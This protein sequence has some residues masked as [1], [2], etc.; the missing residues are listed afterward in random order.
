[1][2]GDK[3][4]YDCREEK[5]NKVYIEYVQATTAG[6][7]DADAKE[8]LCKQYPDLAPDIEKFEYIPPVPRCPQCDGQLETPLAGGT[9][10]ASCGAHFHRGPDLSD[11]FPIPFTVGRIELKEVVGR[12]S[13]GTVYRGWDPQIQR[14]VAVKALRTFPVANPNAVKRFLQGGKIEAQ[15]DFPGGI[16]KVFDVGQEQE[17]PY[18][19]S[20][21]IPGE[22]LAN[23]IRDEQGLLRENRPSPDQAAAYVAAVADA[24]EHAHQ[25]GVIHRD[26]KPSNI[27]M[28]YGKIP[29][30]TDFGLAHWDAGEITTTVE[31][32]IIG[33]LAYMSPEQACGQ[34]HL[35]DC[36]SDV[37]SLGV[38]LYELL[39]DERPFN[40]NVRRMLAQIEFDEP[41]SPRGQGDRVPRDLETICLRC[42]RKDP[43]KRFKTAADLAADLRRYLKRE[44]IES[45]PVG[46]LERLVSWSRR[47]PGLAA[48]LGSV[49]ILL[50]A[51]A[52]VSAAW[53]IHSIEQKAKIQEALDHS[54][55][56][57]AE[58]ELDRGL[59][60]AAQGDVGLGMLW[61][62]RSLET[63][64]PDK[65]TLE[66][67]IRVNLNAWRRELYA[68]T[69]CIEA[70]PGRVLGFS[71]DGR[72]AWFLEAD[73]RTVRGWDLGS[74]RVVGRELRNDQ[75]VVDFFAISPD[76]KRVACGGQ[77]FGVRVW[78]VATGVSEPS[79]KNPIPV[80]GMAYT[81]DSKALI[82]A[83]KPGRRT[84]LTTWDGTELHPLAGGID[85]TGPMAI[86]PE[87]NGRSLILTG[88]KGTELWRW[89][90][91]EGQLRDRLLRQPGQLNKVAVSPDG[92]T[93]LT[94]DTT[95]SARVWDVK[96]GRLLAVLPHRR[97]ITALSF[98]SNGKNVLTADA[99]DAIRVWARPTESESSAVRLNSGAVRALAVS[100]DGNLV[101]TR[102]DDRQVRLWSTANGKLEPS[103]A[104]LLHLKQIMAVAFSPTGSVLATSTYQSSGVQ[105]WDLGTRK[106]GPFLAH[107]AGVRKVCFNQDGGR[108]A[109]VGFDSNVWVWDTQTGQ[110][111]WQKP[112]PHGGSVRDAAFNPSG[113]L[114]I[115][116]GEDRK[117][118]RWDMTTGAIVGAGLAHD[119]AIN[120]VTFH[121]IDPRILL[122]AGDDGIVKLWNVD[123]GDLFGQLAHGNSIAVAT[124]TPDG[125]SVMTGGRDGVAR[126]WDI[127]TG[128]EIE[129]TMRHD[130]GIRAVAVSP[131]GKWAVT[132]GDDGTGRL[133]GMQDGRSIGRP[134]R[135]D[136]YALCAAID[137]A[138]RWVFTTGLDGTVRMQRAPTELT[139]SP[140][141]I[142]WRLR[143]ATG[144]EL[145]AKGDARPVAPK[146][147]KQDRLAHN[148]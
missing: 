45:R 27:L 122:A 105:L 98:T 41:R 21:Y 33:T 129:R 3:R 17:I 107:P 50:I 139:G 52:S 5:V 124:F 75:G 68:L 1:M 89:D 117:V 114:L 138:D 30:L 110:S 130:D 32:K 109:T 55:L 104:P 134:V 116:A 120:V 87:P 88:I 101:A 9:T 94:G 145:D 119:D 67:I 38:V 127:A 42:L 64:P 108:A 81:H 82:L 140:G 128:R 143:V 144:T 61:M 65:E 51:T 111:L 146:T 66:W 34:N 29:L 2:N 20:E 49:A 44:P 13:F 16:V 118:S 54:K 97:P 35:V 47:K 62:A 85:K 83:I 57:R 18:I 7:D 141:E 77:Q 125:R 24:L 15:L 113:Q 46:H 39:T 79:P 102:G 148:Q 100:P 86:A 135:H 8:D 58:T 10:C 37:Y 99:G 43:K 95:S 48:S 53:A 92:L 14:V 84:E 4:E 126:V 115:T 59:A 91:V 71:P 19:I 106:K 31:G 137:P 131:N 80:I 69:D 121:P 90:Q 40:G 36:R 93:I 70:P 123:S 112:L 76:G 11:P 132:A 72:L 63:L 60:E 23:L 147:W 103:G 74:A 142:A 56:V 96:S 133:W 28:K 25:K 22:T 73:N 78:D 26:V 6:Q 12:G 136:A